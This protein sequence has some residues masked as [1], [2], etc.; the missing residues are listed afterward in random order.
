MFSSEFEVGMN[1]TLLTFRYFGI[2]ECVL[3][4]DWEAIMLQLSH[5]GPCRDSLCIQS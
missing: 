4:V 5:H 1:A 2:V 3:L